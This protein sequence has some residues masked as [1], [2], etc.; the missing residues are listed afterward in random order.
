M[1]RI[2]RRPMF[3]GGRVDSRGTGIASGLGKPKRGFVDEP[4][5]YAGEEFLI[6][7]GMFDELQNT[8]GSRSYTQYKKPI[9]PPRGGLSG[10]NI[11]TRALA[12]ARNLPIVG[13][14]AVPLLGSTTSALGAGAGV[15]VG[16]GSLLDFYAQSTK[17]PEEYRRLKEMSEFGI[18]DETNLDVGEAL[19]YIKEG[20]EIGEAPGFFPRGGKKKYFEEKGLNPETGLPIPDTDKRGDPEANLDLITKESKTPTVVTGEEVDTDT[21]V[22]Q[23]DLQDMIS[24]YEELLGGGKARQRDVGDILGRASA[25]F[26]GAGDVREG[27]KEFMKAESQAGPS[28]TERIKQAAAMLGIKGEQ[29]KELYETKLKNEKGM[30]TK[31][32]EEIMESKKVGR[33]EAVNEALGLPANLDSAVMEFKKRGTGVMTET[34]FDMLA[35]SQNISK[36]PNL[37]ISQ[38][39]DGKYYAPGAK[40]IVFIKD[41]EIVDKQEYE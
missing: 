36:L 16:L 11:Y 21:T 3:R 17:T 41:H 20:G 1:S 9:G 7:Q 12:K 13:R 31:K 33:E 39:E 38:I 35:R 19:D 22:G 14:F 5:S 6:G 27:L 32:V 40:T 30:F 10:G 37:D 26:L 8:G 24:R 25:A 34:D 23:T 15:G 18:M 2:L 4:G 29:A 28:R